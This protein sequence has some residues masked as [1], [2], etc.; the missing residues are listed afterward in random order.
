MDGRE[1]FAGSGLVPGTEQTGPGGWTVLW[2]IFP[3]LEGCDVADK[4]LGVGVLLMESDGR[5][6]R[7]REPGKVK[8]QARPPFHT[9]V[10]A[11]LRP[12]QTINYGREQTQSPFL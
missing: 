9:E 8:A 3:A 10:Y 12:N 7:G 5:R 2:D 6:T 11:V 1:L 4:G